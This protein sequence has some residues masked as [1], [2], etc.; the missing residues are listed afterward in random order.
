MGRAIA[1]MISD[2]SARKVRAPQDRMLGNSQEGRPYRECH[3]KQTA[4][5][6]SGKGEMVR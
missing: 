2:Q 5:V 3:R 6:Q 4:R 1:P